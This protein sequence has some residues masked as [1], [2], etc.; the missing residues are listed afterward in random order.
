M[1]TKIIGGAL[2]LLL[3]LSMAPVLQPPHIPTSETMAPA[4]AAATVS[5]ADFS[6]N[7]EAAEHNHV[8]I[9]P[10]V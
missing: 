7:L 6:Y 10:V 8:A 2:C 9:E 5:H 3:L 4:P 1:N